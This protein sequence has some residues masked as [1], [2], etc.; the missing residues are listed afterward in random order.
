MA[1]QSFIIRKTPETGSYLQYEP[2]VYGSASVVGSASVTYLRGDGV[3]EAPT[4]SDEITA[5]G[6]LSKASFFK[7]TCDEYGVVDISWGL[8]LYEVGAQVRPYEVVI[9]YSSEGCPETIGEGTTLIETRNISKIKQEDVVGPWAYYTMFVR[10]KSLTSDYYEPVAKLTVLIPEAF[11]STADLYSKIPMNYRLQ[12]EQS[13][14]HLYKYLSVFGWDVDRFRTLIRY[15]VA[16]KD[17]RVA[18]GESLDHI[19][20][21]LGVNLSSRELGVS[22]LRSYIDSI[23]KV[24]RSKGTKSSVT[25]SLSSISGSKVEMT[26]DKIYVYPQRTNFIKD[27]RFENGVADSLDMGNPESNYIVSYDLGGP[28]TAASSITTTFDGGD[29]PSGISL[30]I[31]SITGLEQWVLYDD[32]TSPASSGYKFLETAYSAVPVNED[33][34]T[35]NINVIG[36]DTFFFSMRTSSGV[37]LQ[38]SAISSVAFYDGTG[39]SGGSASLIVSDTSPQVVGGVSYWKLEVPRSITTYTPV[40]LS[41]RYDSS[42]YGPDDFDKALLEKWYLGDYFDGDVVKGGWIVDQSNSVS[43]YRWLGTPHKSFSVYTANYQKTRNVINRIIP[44]V[45]PIHNLLKPSVTTSVASNQLISPADYRYT[46]EHN[47]IP[48]VT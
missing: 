23:G 41:I 27:P 15:I 39:S 7:A 11:G 33:P 36:G 20:S 17:P 13:S 18:N 28:S 26:S 14:Y 19:A 42:V 31:T 6:L 10:F 32:N 25:T 44:E 46:I 4:L 21:D 16:M 48:G 40:V 38:N 2:G 29:D 43:D 35:Y 1:L 5:G 37:T 12:D 45:I 8:T 30:S 22:R 24:R 3:Q 34:D 9:V 47:A